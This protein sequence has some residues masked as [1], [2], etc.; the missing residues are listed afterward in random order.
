MI[1][2]RDLP[3]LS[4]FKK[5]EAT[6]PLKLRPDLASLVASTENDSLPVHRWFRY[7]ESFSPSIVH[8]ILAALA[9]ELGSKFRLLDPFCGV[10]TTL[11]AAQELAGQGIQI[12][13]TG[14][15]HNPFVRLVARTKCHWPSIN[16]DRLL[17]SG[18]LAFEKAS[19]SASLPELSSIRTSRCISR[20]FAQR[21]VGLRNAIVQTANG[22][23]RHALLVGLASA[24]EPLSHTRKDGRALRLVD[25]ASPRFESTIKARWNVISEDVALLRETPFEVPKAR[26]VGGDGRRPRAAGV[27]GSSIDVIITSPPY[28]NNIDYNEVYK[29]ELWFL[30]YVTTTTD[31]LDLRRETF[32]SHPTARARKPTAEFLRTIQTGRLGELLWPLIE[33][34]KSM[35]EAWRSRLLLGY[36]EDLWTS[37]VEYEKVLR[38][39][40]YAVF[41]VGNSLHGGAAN[42][43]LVPTD[44][45]LAELG[46]RAGF[47]VVELSVAR[48]FRRRLSGN[49]F[50][51]ETVVTLRKNG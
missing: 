10:G 40:G 33:R 5:I 36:F 45:V 14:I 50:L 13:A 42:P 28:P 12:D 1:P 41:I 27:A 31:F 47:S 23:E 29:L 2:D 18:D 8:E 44:L 7:K 51:R 48:A 34:A 38:S 20:H 22:W 4:A 43:Y 37:L 9:D 30:Q 3:E 15:E 35:K 46:A 11:L 17:K 39:D 6:L 25:R 49:H 21:L 24:I 26:V 32:R 16:G 19:I